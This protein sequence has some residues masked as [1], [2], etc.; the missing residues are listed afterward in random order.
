MLQLE[1]WNI[2]RYQAEKEIFEK[3]NCF[4]L[5][6]LKRDEE[7]LEETVMKG[8]SHLASCWSPK[9]TASIFQGLP[10]VPRAGMAG[11]CEALDT[12]DRALRWAS[13]LK[14]LGEKH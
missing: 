3:Y 9:Y 13:G 12:R 10:R 7:G 11:R 6:S 4:F 5:G 8:G 2:G 14:R 1:G